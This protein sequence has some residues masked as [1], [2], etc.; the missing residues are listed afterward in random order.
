MVINQSFTIINLDLINSISEESKEIRKNKRC[1]NNMITLNS[2]NISISMNDCI[3][4]YN[5]KLLNFSEINHINDNDLIQKKCLL[6]KIYLPK[7]NYIRYIFELF[8]RTILCATQGKIYRVKLNNNDSNHEILSF[9]ELNEKELVTKIIT[10]ET[11]FLV[12]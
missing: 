2:G 8:D 10:L 4:I 5:L 11:T 9:I 7:I 1:I 6:Q 3:E 12:T